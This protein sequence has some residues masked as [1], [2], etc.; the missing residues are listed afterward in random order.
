MAVDKVLTTM[1]MS[2]FHDPGNTALIGKH[3]NWRY[4]VLKCSLTLPG[5]I[6]EINAGK[7]YIIYSYS[8]IKRLGMISIE[9]EEDKNTSSIGFSGTPRII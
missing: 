3:Y 9:K 6:W 8:D 2:P 5:R 1:E 4:S 7:A